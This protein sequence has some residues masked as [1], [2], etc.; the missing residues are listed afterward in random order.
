MVFGQN[1]YDTVTVTG[2]AGGSP[3]GLVQFYDC[4]PTPAPT[5]CTSTA[6]PESLAELHN[7]AAP[8]TATATTDYFAPTSSGYWCFAADYLGSSN[9]TASS[10]ATTD[11][12]F[13]ASLAPTSI[14]TA[15]TN[16][17]I[18]LGQSDTDSAKVTGGNA[19]GGNP[20][21]T[22]SFYECG[23]TTKATSCTSKAS[24]VGT[25]VSVTKA[26]GNGDTA[27]SASFKPTAVG[28]WCFA[29]YYSGSTQYAASS[30]KVVGECV[31]VKGPVTILTKSLPAAT[32]GRGYSTTL[33]AR[34][35]TTPYT[36]SHTG[37][38]PRGI[39]MNNSSGVIS[40]TP[41]VTGS[42][43]ITVKVRDSGKPATTA[44]QNLTVVVK[45]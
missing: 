45:G 2:N 8:D 21:G 36:W 26:S 17:T 23:P 25:P 30:D 22:V 31:D 1:D 19:V 16:T 24:R 33:A 42:F 7:G 9:Y 41:S 20:K 37:S 35:G 43:P 12:C 28:Y 3:T 6:N 5:P 38:L 14:T 40:G 32:K 39:K 29:A 13:F 27:T 10:D 4:G 11:E 15:P 44:T 18:S 34:G